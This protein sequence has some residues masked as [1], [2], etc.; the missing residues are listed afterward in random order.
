MEGIIWRVRSRIFLADP[1][2]TAFL[3]MG[4]EISQMLKTSN[5]G[6]NSC[7]LPECSIFFEYFTVQFLSILLS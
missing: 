7:F 6:D 3:I 2:I 4:L 5:R 1:A